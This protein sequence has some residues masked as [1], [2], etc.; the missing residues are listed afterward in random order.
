MFCIISA[1]NKKNPKNVTEDTWAS[2]IAT[3]HLS[4][5]LAI[6]LHITCR[7][8]KIQVQEITRKNLNGIVMVPRILLSTARASHQ[9]QE[10]IFLICAFRYFL[11]EINMAT[12]WAENSL[13]IQT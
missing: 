6:P 3:G 10:H 4:A 7:K 1:D 5:V 8:I 13:S 2:E 11:A 12:L 9:T